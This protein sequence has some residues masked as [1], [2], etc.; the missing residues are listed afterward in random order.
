MLFGT[1]SFSGHERLRF[2][3]IE[4]SKIIKI[5]LGEFIFAPKTIVV[6]RCW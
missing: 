4:L 3:F 6:L 2:H 5:A 1:G